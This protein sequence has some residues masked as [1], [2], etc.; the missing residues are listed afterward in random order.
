MLNRKEIGMLNPQSR[1]LYGKIFKYFQNEQR[2]VKST[3]L[4]PIRFFFLPVGAFKDAR[5]AGIFRREFSHPTTI[6]QLI[7][8]TENL[9]GKSD[10]ELPKF[11]DI[12][13]SR[14]LARFLEIAGRIKRIKLSPAGIERAQAHLLKIREPIYADS[15]P[16]AAGTP[17]IADGL[18][19]SAFLDNV[20]F[21][22][23]L[24]KVAIMEGMKK[25]N[26]KT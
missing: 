14:P 16:R 23:F 19:T 1:K 8:R 12:S 24:R 22:L 10:A 9:V 21:M 15:Q 17:G 7:K 4:G 6:A 25:K 26:G 5:E 3:L 2:E 18:M 20:H 11:A 13:K